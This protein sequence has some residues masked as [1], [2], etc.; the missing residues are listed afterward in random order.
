MRKIVNINIVSQLQK[1]CR[2]PDLGKTLEVLETG[3][4][5]LSKILDQNQLNN[6]TIA[7]FRD[8]TLHLLVKSSEWKHYFRYMTPYITGKFKENMLFKELCKIEIHADPSYFRQFCEEGDAGK[9]PKAQVENKQNQ[10]K[11]DSIAYS[12]E[13]DFIEDAHLKE[14]LLNLRKTLT[15]S[16]S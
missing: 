3:M 14:T 15:K 11:N 6:V 16:N 8:R 1:N 12:I 2:I 7:N 5:I 4:T 13:L 10:E 9:Q